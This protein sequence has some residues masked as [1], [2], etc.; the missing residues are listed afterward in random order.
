[1]DKDKL[2]D[3]LDNILKQSIPEDVIAFGF[4]LYEDEDNH[5]S[6]ELVGTNRFDIEDEDWCCDEITD[7]G[8]RENPFMWK[9]DT[10]WN[11]ILED[12]IFYLKEYLNVGKYANVLKDKMGIGV[13][14]VD[15]D[16]EI[17][18]HQ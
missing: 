15:G 2:S 7:F 10:T 5:W 11:K 3:W 14:F 1:M 9:Q 4:N 18:Y 6:I 12:T 13:G 16:L 8:T 17:I